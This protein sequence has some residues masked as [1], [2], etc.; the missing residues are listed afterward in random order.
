M[1]IIKK[2]VLIILCG[3][4]LGCV[5][6]PSRSDADS[7][8][9]KEELGFL[10]GEYDLTIGSS[11]CTETFVGWMDGEAKPSFMLGQN[12]VFSDINQGAVERKAQEPEDCTYRSE[13]TLQK[14]KIEQ[15]T[16]IKCLSSEVTRKETMMVKG[17]KLLYSVEIQSMGKKSKTISCEYIRRK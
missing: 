14:N 3:V 11:P 17:T 10:P 2:W 6:W 8:N 5:T 4:A 12:I 15:S 9:F 1:Q 16:N 13:T 7:E